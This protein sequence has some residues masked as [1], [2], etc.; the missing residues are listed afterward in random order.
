MEEL[1]RLLGRARLGA[2][3]NPAEPTNA[4]VLKPDDG[5]VL[6]DRTI[7]E[8]ALATPVLGHEGHAGVDRALRSHATD[9][10]AVDLDRAGCAADAEDRARDLRATCPHQSGEPEDLAATD[11]E[12]HTRDPL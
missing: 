5:E 1:P 3:P 12:R 11:V 6:A 9:P 10:L 4:D 7:D 2:A 8:Q